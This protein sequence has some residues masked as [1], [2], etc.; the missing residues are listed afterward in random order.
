MAT[1]G[2]RRKDHEGNRIWRSGGGTE[3][4]D[5]GQSRPRDATIRRRCLGGSHSKPCGQA[6]EI[7]EPGMK[8]R[9]FLKT[10]AIAIVGTAVATSGIIEAGAAEEA[11]AKFSTLRSHEAQTLLQ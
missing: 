9:E 8:R 2:D 3:R 1:I 6:K 5:G 7:K 11:A 4:C 10:G